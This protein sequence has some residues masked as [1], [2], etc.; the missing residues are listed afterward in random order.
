M[1]HLYL[2]PWFIPLKSSNRLSSSELLHHMVVLLGEHFCRYCWRLV[3]CLC[4]A[5]SGS[6]E[7]PQACSS[8]HFV[9][10]L[11]LLIHWF[12][13]LTLLISS[14]H[15]ITLG[16]KCPYFKLNF[17][18]SFLCTTC[19][20]HRIIFTLHHPLSSPLRWLLA[21]SQLAPPTLVLLSKC[22]GR[23]FVTAM[24]TSRQTNNALPAL[25]LWRPFHPFFY[26]A[27]WAVEEAIEI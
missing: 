14:F 19:C 2:R 25:L 16:L 9:D 4:F 5:Q 3:S 12:L 8:F 10:T 15:V 17:F 13:L 24:T 23:I 21:F 27:P 6:L 1:Y 7:A 22:V 11:P 26:T 20:D 18:S